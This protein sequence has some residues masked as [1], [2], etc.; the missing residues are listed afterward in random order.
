MKNEIMSAPAVLEGTA[1]ILATTAAMPHTLVRTCRMDSAE[2]T[3]GRSANGMRHGRKKDWL[4]SDMLLAE[5]FTFTSA[6]GDDHISKR[7][8]QGAMLGITN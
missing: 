7:R 3:T 6:A 4:P 5:D 1:C 8:V 2:Q